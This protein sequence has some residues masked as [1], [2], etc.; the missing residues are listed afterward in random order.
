MNSIEAALKSLLLSVLFILPLACCSSIIQQSTAAELA[1]QG[2]RQLNRGDYKEALETAERLIVLKRNEGYVLYVET[3]FRSGNIVRAKKA[4]EEIELNNIQLGEKKERVEAISSMVLLKEG[5]ID[6]AL[7]AATSALTH[8]APRSDQSLARVTRSLA[9]SRKHDFKSAIRD[10]DIVINKSSC[11][12]EYF[13]LRG[14]YYEELGNLGK[15]MQDYSSALCWDPKIPSIYQ[16]RAAI[17]L[18]LGKHLEAAVELEKARKIKAHNNGT[19]ASRLR[20]IPY[21]L[22]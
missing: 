17:L 14:S 20:W 18:R 1:E 6:K 13:Y 21:D 12:P 7:H 9:Y 15:A 2:E 19:N 3:C 10:I 22:D 11:S 5:E 8:K 4:I 16:R